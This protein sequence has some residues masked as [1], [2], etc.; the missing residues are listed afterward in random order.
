MGKKT[1]RANN[2]FLLGSLV[3]IVLVMVTVVI[4]LF[5]AFRLDL[6][7]DNGFSGR[8]EIVLDRTTSGA[9]LSVYVNDSLLF[10]GT[11][12]AQ[13][14]LNVNRFAEESSLLVVDGTTDLVTVHELP[15]ESSRVT[16]S[17]NKEGFAFETEAQ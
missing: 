10:S 3:L 1:A 11:P 7:K 17:R 12:G 15:A 9:P 8:Y 14:T 4:F 13:L 16:V 5:W 2:N 6:K